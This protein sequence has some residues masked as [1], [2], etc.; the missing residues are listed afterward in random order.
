MERIQASER[1]QWQ[2]RIGVASIR[3]EKA[4]GR[5]NPHAS[6]HGSIHVMIFMSRVNHGKSG[7][8]PEG[9]K[10]AHSW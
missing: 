5:M 9:V 1:P 2:P 7:E 8:C 6:P 10:C 4:M 3:G